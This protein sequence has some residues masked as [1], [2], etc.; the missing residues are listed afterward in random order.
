M[1]L[2]SSPVNESDLRYCTFIARLLATLDECH[3]PTK[4]RLLNTLDENILKHMV[5]LILEMA[6]NQVHPYPILSRQCA[7]ICELYKK[8]GSLS[9]SF[10]YRGTKT[11][12]M[13]FA[14]NSST[15]LKVLL[16]VLE[17]LD[18]ELEDFI[19]HEASILHDGWTRE[20]LRTVVRD[21][22]LR[23]I[24]EKP[25][26]IFFETESF[27]HHVTVVIA[28][29]INSQGSP[30]FSGIAEFPASKLTFIRMED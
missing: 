3:F 6:E 19:Q 11:T 27:A 24:I 12:P 29:V 22:G 21:H 17:L 7:T 18:S 10:N 26:E 15:Q 28:F 2:C 4:T 16:D 1:L 13:R 23:M 14:L 8:L 25:K 20:T 5:L 30:N 9:W